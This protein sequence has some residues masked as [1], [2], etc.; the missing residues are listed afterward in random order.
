LAQGVAD[1]AQEL[2]SI[3]DVQPSRTFARNVSLRLDI[4]MFDVA[5][6]GTVSGVLDLR[7]TGYVIGHVYTVDG[8]RTP[9]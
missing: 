3:A 7:E 5:L 1:L 6:E 8:S 4:N 9:A 2:A